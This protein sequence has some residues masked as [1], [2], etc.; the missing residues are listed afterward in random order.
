LGLQVSVNGVAD[1]ITNSVI[2]LVYSAGLVYQ[3]YSGELWW[4][5]S[6]PSDVWH[7]APAPSC[8]G[9]TP[10]PM[11]TP[12]PTAT[13][14][15]GITNTIY[16]NN[17]TS[18][19]G[20]GSATNQYCSIQN[21]LNVA[22]PGSDIRIQNTGT[23]YN[24]SDTITTSGTAANPITIESDNHASPPTLTRTTTD[25]AIASTIVGNAQLY[26]KGTS[27]ITVQN[28]K[29]DGTNRNV[30]MTAIFLYDNGKAPTGVVVQN[31]TFTNWGSYNTTIGYAGINN[32]TILIDAGSVS[33]SATVQNNTITGARYNAIQ[34]MASINTKILNNTITGTVCGLNNYNGTTESE[35]GVEDI[36]SA[37]SIANWSN[38][39]TVTGNIITGKPGT[40]PFNLSSPVTCSAGTNCYVEDAG[41]HNDGGASYG[42][43][44]NNI[45]HDNVGLPFACPIVAIH[46]EYGV[47]GAIVSNNLI[48]NNKLSAGANN[49]GGGVRGIMSGGSTSGPQNLVYSNTIYLPGAY[50]G[51]LAYQDTAIFDNLVVGGLAQIGCGD[52]PCGPNLT[53]DYNLLWPSGGST[54]GFEGFKFVS[55][56]TWK[57]ATGFDTHSL[58]VDPLLASPS[59]G[60]FRQTATSPTRGAGTAL[61][62]LTVDLLRVTR[63]SP[64]SMGA[65]EYTN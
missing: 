54:S 2:E 17:H 1:P 18:C 55:F 8:P 39:E 7:S 57:S 51:I 31:D 62:G 50:Q 29:W 34:T 10:T 16:V 44:S 22:G 37:D 4:Y 61:S 5:K 36:R 32:S 26:L 21:A 12:S 52:N 58:N 13:P 6:S 9:A 63:P 3:E 47:H 35:I 27:Y 45:I 64:P 48:Y 23:V 30:A 43:W 40:C 42:S 15:P 60:N 14:V 24:E 56:A 33:V 25:G 46:E 19:P 49:C 11:P 65:Y 38:N 59:T 28:L 53:I 20:T 41:I